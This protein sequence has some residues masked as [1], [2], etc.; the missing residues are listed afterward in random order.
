MRF[1]MVLFSVLSVVALM[2]A[3]LAGF[4]YGLGRYLYLRRIV[5]ARPGDTDDATLC[6]ADRDWYDALPLWE[7]VLIMAWWLVNRYTWAVKGYK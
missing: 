4:S 2:G 7:R 1:L 5:S 6:N 3:V